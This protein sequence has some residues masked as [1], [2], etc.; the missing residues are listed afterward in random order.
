MA[1]GSRTHR[2]SADDRPLAAATGEYAR[3]VFRGAE[4]SGIADLGKYPAG[5]P[6]NGAAIGGH[7]AAAEGVLLDVPVHGQEERPVSA[8]EVGDHGR[9]A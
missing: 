4:A 2:S 9:L 8:A 1:G 6:L 5:P 3:M 7:V